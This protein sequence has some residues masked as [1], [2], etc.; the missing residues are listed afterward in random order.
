MHLGLLVGARGSGGAP[1]HP[2]GP[3]SFLDLLT[4]PGQC[5]LFTSFSRYLLQEKLECLETVKR[6]ILPII[7]P[8]RDSQGSL[9]GTFLGGSLLLFFLS[10]LKINL[11]SNP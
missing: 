10:W 4:L 2:S 1:G 7:P 6:N 11:E 9:F 5:L 3:G 8:L